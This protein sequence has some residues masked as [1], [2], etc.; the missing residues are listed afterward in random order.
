MGDGWN[1]PR[2]IDPE[3]IRHMLPFMTWEEVNR[4]WADRQA[5]EENINLD[6]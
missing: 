1:E 3:N 4:Y 6:Y 2:A 5:H